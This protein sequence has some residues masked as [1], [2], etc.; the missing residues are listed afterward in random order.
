MS[1]N[2][3]FRAQQQQIPE[4]QQQPQHPA[5]S[6]NPFANTNPFW[7][8]GV[9]SPSISSPRHAVG[10]PS[11]YTSTTIGA[12]DYHPLSPEAPSGPAGRSSVLHHAVSTLPVATSSELTPLRA[13]YLKKTL[14][15]LEIERELNAIADPS[16]GAAALG[17]LGPPFLLLD[18]DGKPIKQAASMQNGALN[19]GAGDLPLLG[20]MFHQFLLPFPFLANAPP[21]FWYQKVQPFLTSFLAISQSRLSP[22]V[23][24]VNT[25]QSES[26]P[27]NAGFPEPDLTLLSEDELK[28][29]NERKKIWDKV[30]KNLAMLFGTGV[31]LK[32]G[33]EVVRI[34]QKEL[35]RLEEQAEARRRKF[36]EREK[37]GT[38][39]DVNVICVRTVTEKG[40]VRNR[41]H[42]VSSE[43][44]ERFF[45]ETDDILVL[46]EFIIRTRRNK[47]P[48]VYGDFKRLAEELRSQ[49]PDANLPPP[50]A[51]DRTALAASTTSSQSLQSPTPYYSAYNP[52]RA[53]YGA[54][55]AGTG[56]A[57][58][59]RPASPQSGFSQ[60]GYDDEASARSDTVDA[61]NASSPLAR[62]KN[63]LTL[64]A[65]L[66]A[67]LA[68]PQV[69]NSPIL[70]SFLLSSPTTLTPAEA[71]DAQ[72]RADVDA[73]RE[74]GRKR[75]KEEAEKRVEALRA[76]LREF[77]GDVM[78][79]K[80]G[81]RA[82][83]DVVK[84]VENVNDLPKAEAS[85]L[86][87][88]RISLAATIFQMFVAAD[89]ASE[90]FTQ[91]KRIHGLMPYFMLKGILKVS[92]PM[93]MIRGV[94]DL[95][96][97]RPFGGQSLIQR[98]FSSSLTEDVRALQDDI[99]AVAEKV[100]DP[101]L[102]QKVEMFVSAPFEI[103]DMLRRD[104]SE[105]LMLDDLGDGLADLEDSDDDEGPD[106]DD[107]WLFEDLMVLMKLMMRKREKE[108]LLA[109][110]FEGTTAELL[111]DI[112]TIFYS[113]LATVYKAASIAD[114]LGDLQNFINDLIR[115]V[116]AVEE[117]EYWTYSL[118]WEICS[119]IF[120]DTVSQEDPQRTVQTFIDLVARHEQSF[121]S[122]VHK[123]HSKGQGLF[124]AL[125]T[126][127][128]RFLAYAR[129]GLH[130]KIDLEF[131]LPYAGEERL[132][133]L[134]EV[135]AVAAYHYKL[136]LAYEE[137]VRRRFQKNAATDDEA[138]L[139]D[140][141]IASLNLNDTVVGEMEEVGE[142][143]EDSSDSEDW[144]EEDQRSAA[145]S[146]GLDDMQDWSQSDS[147]R[148]KRLS[149]KGHKDNNVPGSANSRTSFDNS[150]SSIEKFRHPLQNYRERHGSQDESPPNE[151][152]PPP[153]K[154]TKI[155]KR[156]GRKGQVLEDIEMPVLTKIP[157]LTP[158]MVEMV[159]LALYLT[160]TSKTL[161]SDAL[162]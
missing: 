1:N 124:D 78:G 50:P 113:P 22:A 77:K 153:A 32:G 18:K 5:G 93:A 98:M 148:G 117:R 45:P 38:G 102:C 145:L 94:L 138:A 81:L 70:R 112:I 133:I 128:E 13:H 26:S 152:R 85:V 64:R 57:S 6:N 4:Q 3:F 149:L 154:P 54:N 36:K 44:F 10:A 23:M 160:I 157:S 66:N 118:H 92:N 46:Q 106:N 33:E 161:T 40:R 162:P 132:E 11:P 115:T 121:Y 60:Q 80:G 120:V 61:L 116:E 147:N 90:T 12:Q 150:R 79:K 125:M 105:Y 82:V 158:I 109:L 65:Y 71:L 140:G 143:D 96:L 97:A 51:K 37:V 88:G 48:D 151:K 155:K 134:R 63:R 114:S 95:F 126:W 107:A 123:V 67:I 53:I 72:R 136:K 100:D 20:Y 156:R 139:I 47:A 42:D 73:V 130:D 28:E 25:D 101:V 52:L 135:D 131:L 59:V 14:I 74:E 16:L 8:A 141:M 15:N 110:I 99:D 91:L 76:G 103:Q 62:E 68:I 9:D 119:L 49:F 87:W 129:D 69:L 29:Y 137:K 39:F 27:S 111:K 144:E 89:S 19:P 55:P 142:E 21:T 127:I 41:S 84:R 30:T 17:R 43:I 108:Q 86:E 56:N 2:P 104:A 24:A 75:F 35:N 122:F 34:G 159:S 58:P 83:F 31:R 7:Q 146:R